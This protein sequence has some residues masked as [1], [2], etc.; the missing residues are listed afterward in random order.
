MTFHCRS[1]SGKEIPDLSQQV[2]D[3][4]VMTFLSAM[5]KDCFSQFISEVERVD[6]DKVKAAEKGFLSTVESMDS[7]GKERKKKKNLSNNVAGKTNVR[8][9]QLLDILCQGLHLFSNIR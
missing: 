9:Q 5:L 6:S 7:D 8:K 2:A 4:D 3:L 1:I